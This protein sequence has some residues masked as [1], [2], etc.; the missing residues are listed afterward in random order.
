M[1]RPQRFILATA[2][3]RFAL[4]LLFALTLLASGSFLA[5]RA[6]ADNACSVPGTQAILTFVASTTSTL[7]TC[8]TAAEQ[9]GANVLNDFSCAASASVVIFQV[10]NAAGDCATQ[11]IQQSGVT[12]FNYMNLATNAAMTQADAQSVYSAAG[13][14][15]ANAGS[16]GDAVVGSP[17]STGVTS[18]G[19]ATFSITVYSYDS[20]GGGSSG[21]GGCDTRHQRCY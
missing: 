15:N 14:P 21:G 17:V 5:P 1:L 8:A 4:A 20:G 19:V 16:A 7:K 18:D 2:F 3:G 11:K 6:H 10:A 13:D 12:Y 9:G